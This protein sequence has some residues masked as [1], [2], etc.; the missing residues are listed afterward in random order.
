M[1]LDSTCGCM[2]R[3]APGAHAPTHSPQ[4]TPAPACLAVSPGFNDGEVLLGEAVM[5]AF[6]CFV[7]HMTAVDVRSVANKVGPGG[8]FVLGRGLGGQRNQTH[9]GVAAAARTARAQLR[10]A[11]PAAQGFAPLAIGF[12]VLLGHAV[13][14]PV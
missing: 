12:T 7:V 10:R 9:C 4:P 3:L 13:L 2:Q 5:T 8:V 6:L 1:G 11:L 14:L